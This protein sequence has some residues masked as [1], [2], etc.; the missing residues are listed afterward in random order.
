M[1]IYQ[2][3]FTMV[4]LVADLDSTEQ[5]DVPP[6]SECKDFSHQ[7]NKEHKQNIENANGGLQMIWILFHLLP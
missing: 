1:G 4:Q 6:K 3:L 7:Q 2:A 5:T